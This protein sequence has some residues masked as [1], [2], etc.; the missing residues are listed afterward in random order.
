MATSDDTYAPW[1][2]S[3]LGQMPTGWG[4]QFQFGQTG[5]A[6][7]DPNAA[8]WMRAVVNGNGQGPYS[9]YADPAVMRSLAQAGY[10]DLYGTQRGTANQMQALGMN[11][12]SLNAAL[13]AQ[14]QQSGGNQ[15][16]SSLTQ[17]RAGAD[18]SAQNF[19][20][21]ALLGS[22]SQQAQQQEFAQ[23][24]AQQASEFGQNLAFQQWAAQHQF[25]VQRQG[26][27]SAM[28]GQLGKGIFDFLGG[29]AGAAL[30]G[31]LVKGGEALWNGLSGLFGNKN[32]QD[33][34]SGMGLAGGDP[35]GGYF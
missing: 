31:G 10:N 23:S 27:Q 33:S 4:Q 20:R 2:Q 30:G 12:P 19:V 32:G 11:D 34:G 24:Q 8:D 26:Q 14:G 13:L 7:A 5:A 28:W 3:G 18:Q 35:G 29:G 9:A 17:A 16:L 22:Y 6:G 15:M 25:D 1:Q 21:Q